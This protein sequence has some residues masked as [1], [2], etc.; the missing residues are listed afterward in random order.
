MPN[1]TRNPKTQA[2]RLLKWGTTPMVE[3]IGK[4]TKNPLL[5]SRNGMRKTAE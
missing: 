2:A 1:S 4:A 5:Q 3:T